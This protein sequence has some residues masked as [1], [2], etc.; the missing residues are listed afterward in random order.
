MPPGARQAQFFPWG[1]WDNSPP[2]QQQ[3]RARAARVPRN[4]REDEDEKV[5]SNLPTPTGPLPIVVSLGKQTVSVYDNN[6][7]IAS[8]P[9]S[10][11]MAGHETPTGIFSILEKNRYHYSNLYGGAPMP[12]MNRITNSGVAMHEGVVPGYPASHGC[13]RLPGSL[14]AQSVRHHRDRRARDRHPRR[15]DA[16]RVRRHPHHRAAAARQRRSNE[17]AASRR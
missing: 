3:R 15:P 7:K 2:W 9:I 14:R 1:G 12:F 6:Q 11:G 16:V 17:C 5:D 4:F 10:S 13:I 8:S